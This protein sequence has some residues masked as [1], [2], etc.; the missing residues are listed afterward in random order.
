L[1]KEQ[2]GEILAGRNEDDIELLTE[3]T[4]LMDFKGDSFDQSLRKYLKKFMLPGEAQK[5]SRIMEVFAMGYLEQNPNAFPNKDV[6]FVLAFSLIMLNTDAHNPAIAAKDKMTK[7][8][9]IWNNRGTWVD[10]ADPPKELLEELYDKIV[11]DEIKMQ[12][13]GDPDKKGWLKGM[14]AG[15]IKEGRRWFLLVGNE[16]RWY[17]NPVVTTTGKDEEMRG[18]IILECVQVRDEELSLKVSISSVLPNKN[19]DFY[20]YEKGGKE[21]LQSCKRFVLSAESLK[22]MQSWAQAIRDNVSL[23]EIPNKL[24]SII[25]L[26]NSP[27]TQHRKGTRGKNKAWR[28]SFAN[29][30][31]G[32]I[33][34]QAA[35]AKQAKK[36]T[37]PYKGDNCHRP[38]K[39]C[40]TCNNPNTSSSKS[41]KFTSQAI[42]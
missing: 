31:G 39:A 32:S 10:G 23:E 6:A 37:T 16:L 14:H 35:L 9:F 41:S 27:K 36:K 12:T 7:E 1:S 18:K 3:F 15:S 24:D 21:I 11:N 2:M 13:K 8:Q 28:N 20:L 5:I 42:D 26:K 19:I 40:G 30:H 4:A 38:S 22:Q 25:G 17:K 34:Q 29:G 33:Q